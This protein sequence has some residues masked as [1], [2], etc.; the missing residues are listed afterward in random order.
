MEHT[1]TDSVEQLL[2]EARQQAR[3]EGIRQGKIVSTM[4]ALKMLMKNLKL[5]PAE[6][7]LLLEI[8][9]KE[10]KTYEKILANREKQRRERNSRDRQN[11]SA[12]SQKGIDK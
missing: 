4:T 10:R 12:F 1:Q 9:R 8:P 6:A 11:K 3:E 2:Q 7:M 5:S